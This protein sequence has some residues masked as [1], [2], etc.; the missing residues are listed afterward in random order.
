M[1]DYIF[2]NNKYVFW[3]V[4]ADI[5]ECDLN[6]YFKKYFEIQD[7]HFN[8][9]KFKTKKLAIAYVEKNMLNKF[10][11]Y[12]NK[13]KE[14]YKNIKI[15]KWIR[16]GF[17]PDPSKWVIPATKQ[18]KVKDFLFNEQLNNGE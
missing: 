10:A 14:L 16:F 6:G 11:R 7:G 8:G 17:N 15:Q 2:S 3:R 12:P 9:L 5:I 18:E 13:D 4:H 1:G